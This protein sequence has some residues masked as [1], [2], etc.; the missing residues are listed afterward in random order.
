ME[1]Y[2]SLCG[3]TMKARISEVIGQYVA[4]ELD[5]EGAIKLLETLRE[6]LDKGGEDV[7]DAIRMLRNFDTFYE[8]ARKKFKEYLTPKKNMTDL[9]KG[10]VLVDKLKL[11]KKDDQRSAVIIFDRSVKRDSIVQALQ[12]LGYEIEEG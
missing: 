2:L 5:V 3:E 7:D 1:Q 12:K 6:E 11:I 8:F 10:R 4:V 9:I